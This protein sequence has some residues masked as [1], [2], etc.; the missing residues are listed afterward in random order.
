MLA[1]VCFVALVVLISGVRVAVHRARTGDH[2]IRVA[3]QFRS[4]SHRNA[5]ILQL[6]SISLLVLMLLLNALDIVRP[7]ID[8]GLLG[9]MVGICTCLMGTVMSMVAQH[10]MGSSWRIG[11]DESEKT[12]LI[13]QGLFALSRNPIYVGVMIVGIGFVVLVPH[14]TVLVSWFIAAWGIHLQV[15]KV[16]E[17]HLRRTFDN[18]YSKYC[19]RVNR[20]VPGF[21]SP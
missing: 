4:K 9:A 21:V 15:T 12:E 2:G 5:L 10:Q 3:M 16:E 18:E 7:H 13:D 14:I 1:L 17:P 8:L 6:L 19:E 11:V 20:Y